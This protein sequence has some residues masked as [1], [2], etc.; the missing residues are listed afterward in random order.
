ME[1]I[2]SIIIPHKNTPQLL[3]RCINSIPERDDVQII[4]VDDDSDEKIVD[5]SKFPGASRKN[6]KT[7]FNKIPL[8]AG[9]ARNLALKIANGKWLLFADADDYY[10]NLDILLDKYANVDDVDIVYFNCKGESDETNRCSKYNRIVEEY[11]SGNLKGDKKIR[12][13]WWTP[14]NKMVSKQ[15][16][17]E[18]NLKFE[19]VM[20]GNDAKFNLLAGYFANRISVEPNYYYVSVIRQDS[21]TLKKKTLDER[22]ELLKVMMKV[23]NFTVW[24]GVPD[25]AYRNNIISYSVI[26]SVLFQYG[27]RGLFVYITQYL[28]EK[29]KKTVYSELKRND[30]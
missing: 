2:F 16:V 25:K 4:I 5:F 8:G 26:K 19:E 28:K 30:A 6:V 23:W 12:F 9:H 18:Y 17:D 14:W 7:I 20:S 11:I 10:I 27:V 3:E 13:N 29:K 15:L 24:V 21:I 1:Y 22:I